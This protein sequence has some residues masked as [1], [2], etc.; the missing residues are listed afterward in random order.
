MSG[1]FYQ[2]QNHLFWQPHTTQLPL[3]SK[4]Q[5]NRNTQARHVSWCRG[6]HS[7]P[8]ALRKRSDHGLT[9]HTISVSTSNIQGWGCSPEVAWLPCFTRPFGSRPTIRNQINQQNYSKLSGVFQTGLYSICRCVFF[10]A[11]RSQFPSGSSTK[12]KTT[13]TRKREDT[14]G[15]PVL[16]MTSSF[17]V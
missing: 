5:G 14:K 4:G 9:L 7:V 10:L 6:N 11:L 15:Y 17:L 3:C 1:S 13:L 2:N 16:D 12:F 8:T